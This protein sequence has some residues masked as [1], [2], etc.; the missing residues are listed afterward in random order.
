MFFLVD[1]IKRLIDWIRDKLT[2]RQFIFFSSVLVGLSAGLAAVVLK[3]FVHFIFNFISSSPYVKS[4]LFYVTLPVIGILITVLIVK[5]FLKGRLD[6]GLTSLYLQIRKKSGFVPKDQMYAQIITSSVT[7][8]FGGSAGLE[9]PIVL[10]GAA[11]GS[12]Y[13]KTYRLNKNDRTLLLAC[14][15]ASGIAAA[16]SAPIAGVLF[17]L[18]VLL[19]DVGITA[20]IPLIIAA[21]SGALVSK[22]IL[23]SQILLSF[24]STTAFDYHNVLFYALLGVLAGLISVYHSRVFL[25]M[26]DLFGRYKKRVYYRVFFGGI[27]LAALIL[28]F[29]SLFGEGYESIKWLSSGKENVLLKNSVLEM[30]RSNEWIV[31]AVVGVII[32]LKSIATGLTL[33]SGGNGGNFAPS[34]F[35]GAY[36]GFFMSRLINSVSGFRLPESN[37]TLVGMAGILSGL[38]HAPL[39]SIFLIAE[40]TGGYTLMIPLMIVSSIS[41]AI[42][43]YFDPQ[44]MD[45]R[46]LVEGDENLSFDKDKAILLNIHTDLVTETRFEVLRP[47]FSVAELIEVV[48]KSEHNI[49]PVLDKKKRFIGVVY[50]D[51]IKEILFSAHQYTQ[52]MVSDLMVNPKQL[53]YYEDTMDTILEKFDEQGVWVLPLLKEGK[54][55]GFISKSKIL[56]EYRARMLNAVIE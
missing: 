28:V 29:P 23:G 43:R 55:E 1:Y 17:A 36:L 44:A 32:F 30:Y 31:L 16:F 2:P 53:V 21:A 46:K 22:V 41:F 18:E 15:V 7:V 56:S 4:Q 19:L 45:I 33:G 34:L 5:L 47:E 27:V 38:Y 49:F 3:L 48:K 8:G 12:N 52:T 13:A 39:T 25:K 54:F 24:H 35:V 11:Y 14:G 40:I 9:A 26:E 51:E 50:V 20:F 6:K 10:T 42:S 37:F